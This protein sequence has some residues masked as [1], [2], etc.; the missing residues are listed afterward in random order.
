LANQHPAVLG[1]AVTEA[2]PPD[3]PVV[4]PDDVLPA[5]WQ[6]SLLERA[7]AAQEAYYVELERERLIAKAEVHYGELERV[8]EEAQIAAHDAHCAAIQRERDLDR[9]A[10]L[11]AAGYFDQWNDVAVVRA[12][13]SR[14]I[15]SRPRERRART[16]RRTRAAASATRSSD[17]GP[18]P[19]PARAGHHRA[20]SLNVETVIA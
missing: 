19:P 20:L 4:P 5:C 17:D 8:Q 7:A 13:C 11:E 12:P 18:E 9:V 6:D 1:A 2:P 16:T 10:E 14:L 15:R 3:E